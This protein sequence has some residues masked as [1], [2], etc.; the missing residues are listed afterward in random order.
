MHIKFLIILI[1]FPLHLPG[2]IVIAAVTFC[3]G[4][5]VDGVVVMG[6]GVVGT[7]VLGVTMLPLLV[8]LVLFPVNKQG[9]CQI[10]T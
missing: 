3:V 8:E 4:W 1:F 5:G 6:T 10:K 9:N 2:A 7:A